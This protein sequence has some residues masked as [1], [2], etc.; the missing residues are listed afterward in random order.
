MR[1]LQIRNAIK[2]VSFI[3]CAKKLHRKLERELENK[4]KIVKRCDDDIFEKYTQK[5]CEKCEKREDE[6]RKTV[7]FMLL[8]M[9]V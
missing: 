4:G 3:V 8:Y 2:S 6:E 1:M 7:A 5:K 9:S